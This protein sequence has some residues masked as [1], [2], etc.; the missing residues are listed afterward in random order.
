MTGDLTPPEGDPGTLTTATGSL[1]TAATGI[2]KQKT[3][4]QHAVATALEQWHGPRS[5]AFRQAGAGLQVE[6]GMVQTSSQKVAGLVHAYG[7]ALKKTQDDIKTWAKEVKDADDRAAQVDPS[8]P[9]SDR[10]FQHAGQ[11][12]GQLEQDARTAARQLK[13]LAAQIAAEIDDET[14]LLVPKS[15]SLSPEAIRR[16]V[17]DELGVT[18][19]SGHVSDAQAWKALGS[20]Q[21]A[22]SK[23][24]VEEDGEVD[25]KELADQLNNAGPAQL[26]AGTIGPLS[27]AEGWAVA[28]FAQNA[29]AVAGVEKNVQAI[30]S[31]MVGPM[32]DLYKS[33]IAGLGDVAARAKDASVVADLERTLAGNPEKQTASLLSKLKAGGIPE[34]GFLGAA[35]RFLAVVGVASDVLTIIN[36]G[37]ENKTEGHVLQGAAALNIAGTAAAFAPTLATLA[38]INAVADWIPVAGQVV[39]IGTGLFLAGDWA[40]HHFGWFKSGVDGAVHGVTTAAKDTWHGITSAGSAI[41]HAFSSIF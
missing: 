30:F 19:L 23:E 7:L 12:R 35:G 27:G 18:G 15:D 2:G 9:E 11:L 28:R 39:M 3:A 31:D 17:F 22:V 36:P 13:Q 5:D 10:A 1:G 8:S 24:D 37:V 26:L 25:W 34:T 38:G 32:S 21:A 33:G 6:L 4:T 29:R 14:A 20:A 16:R 41:G 40:Y